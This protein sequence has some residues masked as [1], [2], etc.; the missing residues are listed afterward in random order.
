MKS[1]V[2][3]RSVSWVDWGVGEWVGGCALALGNFQVLGKRVRKKFKMKIQ[4]VS[5]VIWN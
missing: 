3:E 4:Q 5:L 1:A 2:H